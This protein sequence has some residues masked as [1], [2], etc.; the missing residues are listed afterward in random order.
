MTGTLLSIAV[1]Q[2][3][4]ILVGLFR[5]K[6]LALLLG[7]ADFGVVST[8]D[9][10]VLTLAT[11]GAVSLPFTAL[12]FLASAHSEHQERFR[13][14][15]AMFLKVLGAL[16]AITALLALGFV[17]WRP[18]IF[19]ADLVPYRIPLRL[20]LLGVPATMLTM[21][22]V[23][24]FAAAQFPAR[25]S[26][27]TLVAAA[28]LAVAAAVGAATAQVGGLYA[29]T[30]A[31][32]VAIVV[33][34][35]IVLRRQ[36]GLQLRQHAPSIVG[37][38]R[39]HPDM[40]RYSLYIYLAIG[41]YTVAI[42]LLRTTVLARLGAEA[43]GMLQAAFSVA[44]TLGAI[45]GAANN[46]VLTP[47]VNRQLPLAVKVEATN[48]FLRRTMLLLLL[49]TVPV[50]LFPR[51][52]MHLLFS[53]A[54]TPAA[55]VLYLFVLWQCVY[56]SG[57][58]YHQLLIGLDDVRFASLSS[59]ASYALVAA[60]LPV[61]IDRFALA[62]VALALLI[63]MSLRSAVAVWRLRHF[64]VT[65]PRR[66]MAQVLGVMLPVGAGGALFASLPETTLTGLSWR[67]AFVVAA[68]APAWW[69]LSDAERS[70]I[71]HGR[72]PRPFPWKP[73]ASREP[74]PRD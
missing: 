12:K 3:L 61:L 5:A 62:G 4:T 13:H 66:A 73:P 35:V 6:V 53:A 65:V 45:L 46:M 15:A 2:V 26:L 70:A 33:A 57:N 27:L 25:A 20:A 67:A 56:Q 37:E 44:L 28:V 58:V 19:G 34:G 39:R 11:L 68:L 38:M 55:A 71:R 23:N 59:A 49:A 47:L 10:V 48:D 72:L 17:A 31:A 51:L 50:V 18:D 1:L 14:A 54:F 24:T 8:I 9:Q 7:P 42:L 29:A 69:L 74:P 63:G 36:F 32:S 60:T 41:T 43:A 30:A 64:A 22:F 52:V 16:G 21:L 40:V